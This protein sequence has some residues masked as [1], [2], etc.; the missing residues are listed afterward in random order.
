MDKKIIYLVGIIVIAAIVALA[1]LVYLEG[2]KPGVNDNFA[3]CLT[4]KGLIMAGTDWCHVCK[5]QKA[6]FGNSFKHID[7]RNCDLEKQ[8]CNEKGVTG[9]PTWFDAEGLSYRGLQELEELALIAE[10]ELEA[11]E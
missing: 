6:M 4:E 5:A 10:C 1:Y 8:W 11:I 9:Y 3:K 7:F 2:M